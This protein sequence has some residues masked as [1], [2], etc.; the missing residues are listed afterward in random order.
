MN[1]LHIC[2]SLCIKVHLYGTSVFL[3]VLFK[4]LAA[5]DSLSQFCLKSATSEQRSWLACLNNA[6]SSLILFHSSIK[7]LLVWL[8]APTTEVH[9][10]SA[11][12]TLRSLS[13]H[14]SLSFFSFSAQHECI[15]LN[16]ECRQ[17]HLLAR[18]P[19]RVSRIIKWGW[20][21]HEIKGNYSCSE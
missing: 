8:S 6:S 1:T 16:Q 15:A 2:M 17:A 10:M 7:S 14:H 3:H 5:S 4:K 21:S 20:F 11:I 12:S 18:N 13:L 9:A 19:V